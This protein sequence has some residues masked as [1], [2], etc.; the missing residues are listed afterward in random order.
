MP[1]LIIDKN[2]IKTSFFASPDTSI[3]VGELER[4][5]QKYPERWQIAFDFLTQLDAEKQTLGQIELNKEVYVSVTEYDT[6][7]VDESCYES[8]K[9]Y[10]DIQYVISGQEYIAVNRNISWL[11]VIS[12]YDSKKDYA[13]YEYDGQ[14]LL[15]ANQKNFFIFFPEDA[16]MPCIKVCKK[17]KVKKLVI[18]IKYN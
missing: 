2:Q 11:K 16:H 17:D 14:K 9:N 10:V 8:H 7:T 1:S 15:L 6:K 3:H 12:P 5:L 18:K 4:H 13:N